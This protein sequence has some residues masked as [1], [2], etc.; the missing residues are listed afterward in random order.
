M[1]ATAF[2]PYSLG[3]ASENKVLSAPTLK[4][5]PIE[6]L[7][8]LNGELK[9][10]PKDDASLE[11]TWIPFGSNRVTP[12]DIRRGERVMVYRVADTDQYY[13]T[14]MG[15]DDNLRRLETVIYAF[16]ANPKLGDGPLE[17]A[18]CYYFEVSTHKGLVTF[19]TSKLNGEQVKYT[20]QLNPKDGK[21]AIVDDRKNSFLWDSVNKNMKLQNEQGSFLQLLDKDFNMKIVGNANIDIGQALALKTGKDAKATIGATLDVTSKGNMNFKTGASYSLNSSGT[22]TIKS[23]TTKVMNPVYM[24]STLNVTG[25]TTGTAGFVTPADA[26][27]GSIS[28]VRH[29]HG[30]GNHGSPTTPSQA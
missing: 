5:S 13:W 12:P 28:L 6:S 29:H 15:L 26:R 8:T 19:Q 25:M 24:T 4:V 17:V 20:I 7:P 1:S 11:C 2:V 9:A 18:N 22:S 10:N 30:N 27:A 16:N 14:E 3:I 23:S 21:L